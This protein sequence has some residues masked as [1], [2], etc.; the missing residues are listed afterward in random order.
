MEKQKII[1]IIIFL[2]FFIFNLYVFLNYTRGSFIQTLFISSLIVLTARGIVAY[3]NKR[4]VDIKSNK[5]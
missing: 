1:S 4:K 3:L 2:F 5:F